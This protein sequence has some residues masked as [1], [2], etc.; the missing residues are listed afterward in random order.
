MNDVMSLGIHRLWKERLVDRLA[1]YP[2][3]KILDIGGGTGDIAFR[4]LA[5]MRARSQ[6]S[7][8][9]V[10]TVCDMNPDM[11][12]VGQERG[13]GTPSQTQAVRWVNGD[14]EGLPFDTASF[15]AC[16]I[17][18]CLRNVTH[19][20]KALSEA[21]RVLKPGEHFLCLEFS[22]FLMPGFNQ[23]YDAYSFHVLPRLGKVIAGDG[24]KLPIFGRVFVSFRR[25][26]CLHI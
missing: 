1:P 7:L 8:G 13:R 23:L 9:P 17:A 6:A 11:L 19:I 10:V 12:A 21:Y 16:T 20:N 15:D 25:R 24:G 5:R 4:I 22:R 3:W 14:A 26:A 18:F 2:S